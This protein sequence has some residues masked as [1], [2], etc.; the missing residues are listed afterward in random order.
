MS[1][2]LRASYPFD[3]QMNSPLFR[4]LLRLT[5]LCCFSTIFSPGHARAGGRAEHV[6]VVVFDGMRPDFITPQYAPNLWS[7]ATNGVFFRRNHPVFISTT[8]VNGT[9]L[10]TGTHP[11]HSGI[12]ANSDYR[13]EL[14]TQSAVASEVLDTIR[15]GDMAENGRYVD[16]D[17]LAEVI[18]AAGHHT[19][20]AGTKSVALLHD[21]KPRRTDTAA[22]SNSVTLGR[23][24]VL[25]R[26]TGDPLKKV[27]DDKSFPDNFTTPNIASDSWTTRALTR[28]LWKR[29][30]PKYSLLWLSDPDVTQ[31]A[32]GVGA[33]DSLA[34]IEASD[35]N[36]G[37]VLHAL[38]ERGALEKTDIFV[39]SDHGFSTISRGADV[40]AVL[41]KFQFNAHTKIENPEPGDV[42]VVPLGGAALIYVTD[43]REDTVRGVARALQTCDFAGVIFS[44][45]EIE[46]T[47]PMSTVRYPMEGHGPDLVLS[48][49]WSADASEHEAPGMLVAT[50]GSRNGGAHGSLSRYEMNNTL[51]AS[52]PDLKRG[53]L[54]D[55]PSGNID[56]APTILHLLGIEP[57][58]SMDGRV[59][60]EAL[61]QGPSERPKI[62]QRTLETR[63]RIGVLEWSQYITI[64]EVAGA[65]YFTEGN[66]K[67]QLAT[68]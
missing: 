62:N 44:R 17:T 31:H 29:G 32:K 41:R 18:Q 57:P 59:L 51:V 15:R 6:V 26:V 48:M 37:E 11:G 23:G 25:P 50:G 49:R 46:G 45:L 3:Y 27:N 61:T 65:T 7:L 20:I 42:L 21:R 10:A 22:H 34:A 47:F 30:I 67:V 66:G 68:P 54:S 33:P 35:K 64:T 2:S 13:E 53:L 19:F 60:H 43:R 4:T 39:V 5:V 36:L 58:S 1:G 8:I 14:N 9:A 52:G 63:R 56:L 28:G 40:A 55:V 16:A 38:R 24:L 12:L